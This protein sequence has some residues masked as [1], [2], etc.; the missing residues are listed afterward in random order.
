MQQA[1]QPF[2]LIFTMLRETGMRVA[3][4]ATRMPY[5]TQ[6][7][8]RFGDYQIAGLNDLTLTDE[9]TVPLFNPVADF[10]RRFLHSLDGEM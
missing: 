9:D 8:K 6:Y 4:S 5:L 10:T 1:P 7:I 2:R 3:T